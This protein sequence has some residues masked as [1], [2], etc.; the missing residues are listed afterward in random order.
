MQWRHLAAAL[1]LSALSATAIADSYTYRDLIRQLTDLESLAVAP[2]PGVK[3]AQWSSYDRASRYDA[4]T[5]EYVGWDANGD[6]HGIIRREGDKQVFAEIEGPGVIWR[7]WSAAPQ[8]GRVRIYLDGA[9]EPAV[10]L[11]FSQYFDNTQWPFVHQPLVHDA[12]SGKNLYVPIPFKK[13]CKVIADDKWGAYYHFTYTTYQKDTVLPVFTRNLQADEIAALEEANVKLTQGLGSDPAGVRP[14]QRT[15][16]ASA[17]LRPGRTVTVARLKGERAITAL[18]VKVS[19]LNDRT[20]E[21]LAMRQLVLKITFD[22]ESEPSV[23]APLGDFF[24]TAPG[25][26]MYK[27]LPMG[28]TQDGC[29]SFWFMPFAKGALVEIV[30]EGNAARR[31]SA[32]V[33]HAPLTRPAGEYARFHAKWHRDAF[34]PTEKGRGIE[35][36]MVTTEGA[37]RF[38]GVNLHVWNPKG[39]W[40]GEGDEMFYVDG[41]KFPSTFGTGSEDYFGYAWCNPARFY[42]AYHNQPFNSG[43]NKGHASVNRWHIADNVPFLTSFTGTIE[44]YFPNDRPTLYAATAY[45]YLM[46]GGKDPY[47]PYPVSERLGYFDLQMPEPFVAKGAIEGED[48]KVLSCTGGSANRQDLDSFEGEWSKGAHVWW[49]EGKPG[50]KLTL[51]LPVARAGRY[52]VKAQFTKAIDYGIVQLWLD[53]KKLGDPMD[54]F[55]NGVIPTGELS[56]GTFDLTAG[57]HQLVAEIVGANEK[58]VVKYMFGL[59]YIRL[60]AP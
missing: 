57:E 7:I 35:W 9:S 56:L 58:A 16:R 13:S 1:V 31:V 3:C 33:T 11:K 8:E 41:E 50:D 19:G 5:G 21:T 60:V 10:D 52:A 2:K 32:E 23:W 49:T 38:V 51:A 45:W 46:P 17:N 54:F 4:A 30:N 20:A 12:S 15:A 29:Y 36:T 37:G 47:T 25:I 40:W 43:N 26:N 28:M 22:G 53:G 18:R 6:G 14:G 24:G 39:G 48:M 59:D 42:N 34:N 27:S 44:K 55:N